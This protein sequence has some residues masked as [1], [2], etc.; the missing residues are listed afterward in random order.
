MSRAVTAQRRPVVHCSLSPSHRR[1]TLVLLLA[2]RVQ[3]D[4]VRAGV[5]RMD[6]EP[7]DG[8]SLFVQPI[9]IKKPIKWSPF[10][11]TSIEDMRLFVALCRHVCLERPT[12]TVLLG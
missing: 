10:R 3:E 4:S 12:E 8:A 5:A 1:T 6:S 7:G 9:S 11:H 2:R